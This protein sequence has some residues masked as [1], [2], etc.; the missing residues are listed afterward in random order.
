MDSNLPFVSIVIP[1]R[2]E[3]RFIKETIGQILEQ[4]YPPD[5]FEVIISD[6]MSEDQTREIV[7]GMSQ[8]H[9]NVRFSVNPGCLPSSGRNVG[10]KNGRGDIFLVIDGH[11]Y[12]PDKNLLRN[13]VRCFEKSGAYCLGRSQ[14]LD[15]PGINDFQKTVSLARASKLG[16]SGSSFIYSNYEGYISPVSNGAIYKKEIFE[17]VGYVDENFDACEDVEFN[18]RIEKAGFKA[19]MS[20]S[21]TVKYYPR[22]SLK[23]LF[24][25]MKRYGMGRFRF[26]NKHPEA[27]DINMLI[28]PIFV[29][30]L[31]V[32]IALGLCSALSFLFP[33]S[34]HSF[35][36]SAA[37]VLGLI[38]G[39][40]VILVLGESLRIGFK[41]G[42]RF[43]KYLPPIFFTIHFGL[44]FG[45]LNEMLRVVFSKSKSKHACPK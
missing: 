19:Y 18:Y 13:V 39:I 9:P 44:G 43:F 15:P 35:I 41:K 29:L 27:A 20:P 14:P 16:H 25:Q 23:G 31:L 10:F 30:G 40:Y 32:L 33:L 8:D 26:I 21:L 4:D 6:G 3:E 2:N 7:L 45:F 11:C 38:Y 36:D 12:I 37:G 5:Q 42:L 24:R 22:D 1:V 28:P 17:K 34:R